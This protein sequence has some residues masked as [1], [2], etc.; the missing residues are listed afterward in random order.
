MTA[1]PTML[2]L[3]QEYL[4]FRRTLGFALGTAGQELLLFARYAERTGHRGPVTTELAVRWAQLPAQA[5]PAYWAWRLQAVRLFAQHR[6]LEDPRTEV[7]PAGLLG[8]TYRRGQP[9]IYSPDEVAALLRAARTLRRRMRPHTCGTL[10][11]LLASTGLRVGEA[12]ALKREHVDLEVGVLSV[13]KSKACKSRLVPLHAS[14]TEALR[15]YAVV[16]DRIHPAPRSNAFFLTDRGTA[17]TYQRVTITFRTLRRQLGWATPLGGAAP[18]V[19]DLRHTFAVRVLLRWYE[20]GADVDENIA[21]L[22][23]YL[24]HV[25]VTCTYWYLTAVPDLMAVT[26][27]RFEQYT[28]RGGLR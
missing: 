11:G 25:N 26:A 20:A 24:G 18:R 14:T 23:T 16:R 9:H 5:S 7:P 6:A 19:H 4:A 8:P 28:D 22:A 2:A 13:I 3:V 12:L 17:L 27:R 1:T 21:A 15:R 10:F